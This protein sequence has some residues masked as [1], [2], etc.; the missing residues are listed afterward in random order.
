LFSSDKPLNKGE[1]KKMT[2]VN[3]SVEQCHTLAFRA[4]RANGCDEPNARAIA[5]VMT[6]AER[7]QCHSHG[8]FRLPLYIGA[9]KSGKVNGSARPTYEWLSP[10]VIQVQGDQGFVPLAQEVGR[11]PLVEAAHEHGIA[12]LS[13]VRTHHFQALWYETSALA[14]MGL[15]AMAFTAFLPAVAPAGGAKPFFGTNPM[16]FAW[17]RKNRPPM[18]FDQASAAMARGEVM[19]AARDGHRLP[20]GAGIDAQGNPTTDP[21]EVLKGALLPFGGYKGAAIA[22]MVELLAGVLIGEYTSPEAARAGDPPSGGEL[23]IAIDPKRFGDP[24]G[25]L[26]HGERLFEELL[27]QEGTRLPADRRY[28]NRAQTAQAGVNLPRSLFDTILDEAGIAFEI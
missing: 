25:Y 6:A 15:C 1:E 18:V 4:L 12:A 9:L 17:P 23:M 14:E 16:A 21:N 2:S 26:D 24:E 22:L 3:L 13:I 5:D 8:L 19:I 20:E 27:A 28:R 7:D 10:S 11:T